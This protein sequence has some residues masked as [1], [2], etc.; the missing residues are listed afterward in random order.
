M[1]FIKIMLKTLKQINV[2]NKKILLRVDFNISF[3]VNGK[4]ID[5]IRMR[6]S[7]PTIR[8]L[9]E[10]KVDKIIIIS[11]LG[12]PIIRPKASI[13]QII[14]G[15][16]NLSMRKVAENLSKLLGIKSKIKLKKIND[17]ILPCYQLNSQIEIL[18]NIRFAKEEEQNDTNFAKSLAKMGDIY[19]NDAFGA[20]HRFHT[21]VVA[22][23]KF[24]PSCA[25]FLMEKEINNLSQLFKKPDKPFILILGG[26]KVA[27]KIQVLKKLVRKSSKILL[28]G[29]MANTFL[30]SKNINLRNS[31]IDEGS[32]AI[33]KEIYSISASK[34]YLPTDL[35]WRND[36]AVDIGKTTIEQYRKII[37]TGNTIFWNGTM[38]L[39]SLGNFK[40][41]FGTRLIIEAIAESEAKNKVICGGDTI[42]EV[43]KAN[44]EDKFSYIST[45]GG[46]ALEFLSGKKLPA[47][48]ALEKSKK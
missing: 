22:I 39:T 3:D 11:H 25:G 14:A 20:S 23:T 18:E 21:S 27:E 24:L 37:N 12:R 34:F 7:L 42:S 28:G 41:S 47:I 35:V 44:M 46:A 17:F 26:A 48:E 30:A 43:S 38:G 4:I 6:Y 8:Y 13:E 33:A 32:I 9:L 36:M 29:V 31:K 19:I 2:E 45:G 5:D 15:N 16:K 10:K 1:R 40:Y